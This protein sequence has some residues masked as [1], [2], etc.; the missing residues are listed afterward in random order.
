MATRPLTEVLRV[1]RRGE[2]TLPR[3]V[4]AA[5]RLE[6]G[7]ELVLTVEDEQLVLR[8]KARRFGEYLDGLGLKS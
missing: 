4:R 3:K 5:F 8:R 1:G 7:D 6:E 2:L